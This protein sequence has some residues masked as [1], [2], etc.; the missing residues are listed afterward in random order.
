[1][2]DQVG[3][4]VD[5]GPSR[6]EKTASVV[7]IDGNRWSMV[8][9]GAVSAAEVEQQTTCVIVFVCTGNTCRS[10]MAEALCV[11]LLAERIGCIPE[12]LPKRGYLV[13]SAGLAAVPGD[14]AAAEAEAIIREMGADL[15]GHESRPL[16]A[17]MVTQADHLIT[18]TQ[19]HAAALIGRFARHQPQPRLLCPCGTDVAD[20]IGG[21]AEVY[22]QCAQQIRQHLEQLLP[23]LHS[24]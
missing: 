17:E 4:I 8:H 5:G 1:V 21:D 20:P 9:E 12:E 2:G 16:T 18:M 23:E 14:R 15:T 11:K 19:S 10:P 7:R 3:L 22:R 6:D 13:L 24:L